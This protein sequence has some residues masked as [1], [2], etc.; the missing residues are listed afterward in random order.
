MKDPASSVQP[1]LQDVPSPEMDAK[2]LGQ[3]EVVDIKRRSRKHPE[4]LL[5]KGTPGSKHSTAKSVLATV[6]NEAQAPWLDRAQGR[7]HLHYAS[8]E[9]PELQALMA[10]P[11]AFAC[12][13]W[14]SADGTKSHAWL[15][16]TR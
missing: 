3:V 11:G 2:R 14:E 7:I 1:L 6:G 4:L 12:Y 15:L 8:K 16:R 5:F 13:F 10:E 9:H